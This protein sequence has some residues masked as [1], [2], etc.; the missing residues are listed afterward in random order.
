MNTEFIIRSKA[1]KMAKEGKFSM[2][3]SELDDLYK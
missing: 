2:V 3:D 1:E